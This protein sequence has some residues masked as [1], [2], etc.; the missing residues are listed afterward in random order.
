MDVNRKGLRRRVLAIVAAFGVALSTALV[1]NPAQAAPVVGFEAGNIISDGLF[2]NGGSMSSTQVQ[3][4]LN[5]QVPRCTIGD[6]GRKAGSAYGSTKIAN[7]C[8]RNFS[9]TT[10]SKAANAFCYSYAGA[11]NETAA[12]IITKVGKACGISQ[13]VLLVLLQKEQGLVADTWPTVLQ[14]SSATGYACPDTA[15]CSATEQGFFNQVY[16]AAW[17]FKVYQVNYKSFGYWPYRENYIQYNPTASCGGTNV[18]IKNTATAGLYIYTPYQPNRNSLNAGFASS[19]DACAAYGNRN[20]FNYY[21]SWFGVPNISFDITG[22]I[23]EYWLVHQSWLGQPKRNAVTLSVGGGGKLQEFDG[24]AVYDANAGGTVGITA[25]SPIRVAYVNAGGIEGTWGWPLS[26]GVNQGGSG[27]NVMQFQ[28]GLVV[29][30]KASG[31][32]LIPTHLVTYWQNSGGFNGSI[33]V[34]TAASK[35]ANGLVWQR[36]QKSALVMSQSGSFQPFDLRFFEA[37]EKGSL[38]NTLGIPVASIASDVS[39]NGG[40]QKYS[41]AN[42]T[43]FRSSHGIFALPNGAMLDAYNDLGG[44]AGGWGWPRGRQLCTAD[45]SSCS[46]DFANGVATWSNDRGV[47]FTPLSASPSESPTLPSSGEKIVGG[48]A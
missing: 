47:L 32:Y 42:G 46:M 10:A 29:E 23:L 39:A 9:M 33:G 20:F 3:S 5:E 7:K 35:A 41:F 48:A 25:T 15:P 37:W 45:G 22:N 31:T 2:Y 6:P 44:P 8:L 30:S 17:Q 13:K 1:A 34:P 18:Y 43:M 26:P 40:G 24:G 11:S 12:Q 21:K 27:N 4:F 19:S 28:G 16:L 38:S 14:F 36:F